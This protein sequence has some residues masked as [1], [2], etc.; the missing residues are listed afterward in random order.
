ME[1]GEPAIPYHFALAL[2]AADPAAHGD[3]ALAL[4]DRVRSYE[5]GGAFGAAMRTLAMSLRE[6][7]E[8][9]PA[10]AQAEA[11]RRLEQ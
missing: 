9:D 4:L 10:A 5:G 11:V 6:L 3:E 1:G 7:L 8:D 2:I